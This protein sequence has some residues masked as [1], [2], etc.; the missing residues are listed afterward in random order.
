MEHPEQVVYV[1]NK[2]FLGRQDEQDHFREI[3]R[4]ALVAWDGDAAPCIVLIHGVGGIG[5]SQPT[6]RLRDIALYDASFE[7]R[8]HVLRVDWEVV[9]HHTPALRLARRQH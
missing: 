8:F 5:K 2:P 7:S 9:R 1:D 4:T 6:R 3:L